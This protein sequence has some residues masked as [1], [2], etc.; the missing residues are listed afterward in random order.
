MLC[1]PPTPPA[2]PALK[3]YYMS[4]MAWRIIKMVIRGFILYT[5]YYGYTTN[6]VIHFIFLVEIYGGGSVVSVH[7]P[8]LV[9][10]QV[11]GSCNRHRWLGVLAHKSGESLQGEN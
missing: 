4:C 7:P 3:H 5:S 1:V 8:A 11:C 2:P 10:G 9:R 6:R